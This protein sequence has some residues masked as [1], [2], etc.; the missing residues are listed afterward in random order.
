MF[1]PLFE[2]GLRRTMQ[3]LVRPVLSKSFPLGVQRRYIRQAYRTSFL[4]GGIRLSKTTLGGVPAIRLTPCQTPRGTLLYLHGGGYVMGSASTHKGLAGYLARHTDCEVVLPDYRLAPEH[5]FPA[6]PDDAQAVYTAL[7][8]EGTAP[9]SLAIAGDSAG[10]GLAVVLAMLLRD[11]NQPLP[12]SITCFS[13][14]TDLTEQALFAPDIEPVLHAGWTYRAARYYAN[15]MPL[16]HPLISPVYGDL[17]GLPP[18]L[19]QVGSQE[20]LLNDAR[21]L[22]DLARQHQVDATLEIYNNLWH[23][24]QVHA[25]QLRRAR[26]A[27]AIAGQHIRSNF[28]D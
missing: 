20:M 21:R 18:L 9:E 14:W 22:A 19:I 10:G 4:P 3:H 7:L 2:A 24:F 15:G 13:P 5:P 6:A 17:T 12:S 23:V 26:E 27:L 28:P 25:P 8:D 11:R 16:A 1:Q